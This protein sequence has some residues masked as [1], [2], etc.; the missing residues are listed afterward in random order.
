VVGKVRFQFNIIRKIGGKAFMDVSRSRNCAQ[1]R[2]HCAVR[3]TFT[4]AE[5]ELEFSYVPKF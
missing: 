5:Y 2:S 1:P 3:H 4:G